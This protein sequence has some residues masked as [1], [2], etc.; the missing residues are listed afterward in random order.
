MSNHLFSLYLECS[1]GNCQAETLEQ[2]CQMNCN[3]K[4]GSWGR[5]MHGL[6]IIVGEGSSIGAQINWEFSQKKSQSEISPIPPPEMLLDLLSYFSFLCLPSVETIICS[7]VLNTF[8]SLMCKCHQHSHRWT[9]FLPCCAN[10]IIT[11][12]DKIISDIR[13]KSR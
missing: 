7:S 5:L 3:I 13:G 8:T 11:S 6:K 4:A 12:N 9:L 10:S 1:I 2:T